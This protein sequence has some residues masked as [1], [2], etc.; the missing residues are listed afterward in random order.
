MPILHLSTLPSSES[1]IFESSSF[2]VNHATL[3]TPDEV[4]RA[5]CDPP[6]RV[7]PWTWCVVRFPSLRLIVKYGRQITMAEGQCLWAVRTLLG[8]TVPV[9]ELY[10]WCR[11]GESTFLYMEFI[12]APTLKERWSTLSASE[13][14]EIGTQFGQIID[15]IGQLELEPSVSEF[16]GAQNHR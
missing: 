10:G 9:P 15:N 12:Q 6:V 4:R 5:A 7:D 16:V 13:R 8:N 3:P 14:E 2:F 1:I 11:D